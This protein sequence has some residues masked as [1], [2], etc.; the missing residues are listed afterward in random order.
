M[1][2]QQTPLEKLISDRNRLQERCLLQEQV[3]NS[4]FI[5]I[6]ENSAS[7]LFSGITWLFFGKSKPA[8]A[9]ERKALHA[10]G[11]EKA[12]TLGFSD[13][14]S[15]GKGM[16]PVVWE[17]V[18]PILFSWGIRKAGTLFTNALFKKKK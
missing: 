3:L 14:I 4:D 18:K 8:P 10:D 12:E 15:I 13:I 1:N 11:N 16:L 2:K 9:N 5:Y 17:I 6:Q 7:L